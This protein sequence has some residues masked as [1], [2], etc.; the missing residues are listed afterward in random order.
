MDDF[1]LTRTNSLS[2]YIFVMFGC[3]NIPLAIFCY[4]NRDDKKFACNHLRRNPLWLVGHGLMLIYGGLTSFTFHASFT[5]LSYLLD[6]ASVFTMLGYPVTFSVL[7]I[8]IDELGP[9]AS[10]IVSNIGAIVAVL[11]NVSLGFWLVVHNNA[12]SKNEDFA[13]FILISMAAIM[14]SAIFI[15]VQL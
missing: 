14:I 10:R 7:N 3:L 15:K 11:F 2:N 5:T 8:F 1:M 9:K 4:Q 13:F 12:L 6:I